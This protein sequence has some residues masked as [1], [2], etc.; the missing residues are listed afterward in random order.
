MFLEKRVYQGSSGRVYP[1]AVHGSHRRKAGR[2]RRGRRSGS[3]TNT[4]ASLV[5]PELGGRIH[6]SS[7]KT[8]GYDLIYDQTVIKPALVGLAG[9]WI[10][11]GIEF[12]WPQHHRP[13]TFLPVEIHDR[14]RARGRIGDR[15]V[16]RPRSD[17][18]D[19]GHARGLPASRT[20]PASSCKVRAYNRTP[21][22][23]DLPLV[24]QCRHPGARSLPEFLPARCPLRRRPR[25]PLD[26][27]V[28]PLAEGHYYGVDYGER[29]PQGVPADEAPSP[30]SSPR[31]ASGGRSRRATTRRTTSPSTRTSPCPPPTCAWA[32]GRISSV[33]TITGREAGIVHVANHHISP[34]KKQWTWGN[35]EFGY[36]WDRNLTDPDARRASFRPTSKSWPAC[37]PTTSPTSASCNPAKPRPG[38]STGIRSSGSAR[39]SRRTWRRR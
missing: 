17:V 4:S 23:A 38:A 36:A 13:A 2:P 35:H 6:A 14:G 29:A 31:I 26:E 37:T 25:P 22:R 39:R 20:G 10:S 16:R 18:P 21:L 32:A 24:G 8:N 5:L 33:A 1:A 30:V 27:R 7:D 15:L 11:G 3:R 28:S 34:G 9:P 12:N 19:E